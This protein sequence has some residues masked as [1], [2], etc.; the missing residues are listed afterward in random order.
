MHAARVCLFVF[1]AVGRS[2]YFTLLFCIRTNPLG[3]EGRL[4][5]RELDGPMHD[6]CELHG[7]PGEPGWACGHGDRHL[8]GLH[9]DAHLVLEQRATVAQRDIGTQEPRVPEPEY[10]QGCVHSAQGEGR[11][12]GRQALDIEGQVA[13]LKLGQD[14]RKCL[15]VCLE[16]KWF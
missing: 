7:R 15:E 13:L 11:R 6:A 9:V 8:P 4:G 16:I 2:L 3:C 5:L 12:Q 14:Q 1:L 10:G